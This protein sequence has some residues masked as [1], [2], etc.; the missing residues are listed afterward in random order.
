MLFACLM[1]LDLLLHI[2]SWGDEAPMTSPLI[3]SFQSM[4]GL[5]K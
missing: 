2:H 1:M 5:K 4:L 3:E